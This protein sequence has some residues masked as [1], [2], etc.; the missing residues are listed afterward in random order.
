LSRTYNLTLN[1]GWAWEGVALYLN[2]ALAGTRMT[3]FIPLD[4]KDAELKK[5]Q[6]KLFDPGTDWMSEAHALVQKPEHPKLAAV[7]AK[8]D[9]AMTAEDLLY[10]YAF[11]A[12]LIEGRPKEVSDIL[13]RVSSGTT[14]S[15]EVLGAVLKMDMPTLE[16][17]V[18][19]WL[20]E[21]H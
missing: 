6:K 9:S 18:D 11:S 13:H 10:A 5:L 2:G 19:R 21:R 12:Y 14:P 3:W 4:P 1:P 20:A 15:A 7:L 8:P 16:E 17:R